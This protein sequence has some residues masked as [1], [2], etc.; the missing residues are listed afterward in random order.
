MGGLLLLHRMEDEVTCIAPEEETTEEEL[1]APED[2][3]ATLLKSTK[4]D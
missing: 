3:M 1:E 4:L 2:D